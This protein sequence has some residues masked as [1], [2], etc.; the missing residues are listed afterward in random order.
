[1]SCN[2]GDPDILGGLGSSISLPNV[3]ELPVSKALTERTGIW[4]FRANPVNSFCLGTVIGQCCFSD[5]FVVVV[6]AVHGCLRGLSG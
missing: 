6:G 2:V 3:V 1:M 5:E 4:S